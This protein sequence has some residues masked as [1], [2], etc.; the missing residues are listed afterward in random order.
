[1]E[2][3]PSP[4]RGT[5]KPKNKHCHL[6]LHK[7]SPSIVSVGFSSSKSIIDKLDC[8][9]L[10]FYV[11]HMYVKVVL[12]TQRRF[13]ITSPFEWQMFVM[14]AIVGMNGQNLIQKRHLNTEKLKNY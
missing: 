12:Q 6:C 1:V 10:V 5:L 4:S 9:E 11:A 3:S 7:F 14:A 2:H 8:R 13:L